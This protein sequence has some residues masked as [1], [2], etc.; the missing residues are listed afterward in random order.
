MSMVIALL[1]EGVT[2]LLRFGFGFQA[3][4]DTRDCLSGI[5]LGVRIH[6]AYIGAVMTLL[7]YRFLRSRPRLRDRV[8][9]VGIAL[10]VSDIIHHFVFLWLIVGDPEF[11]LTYSAIP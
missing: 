5:T 11:H 4:R 1:L 9:A 10:M 3:T 7:G 2:L 6:H 8:L